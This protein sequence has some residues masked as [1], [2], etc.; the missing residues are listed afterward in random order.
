MRK[1]ITQAAVLFALLAST[2]AKQDNKSMKFELKKQVGKFDLPPRHQGPEANILYKAASEIQNFLAGFTRSTTNVIS[3]VDN[4]QVMYATTMYL[5]SAKKAFNVQIDTG[6]NILVIQDSACTTCTTSFDTSTS[7]S[8]VSSIVSDSIHYGDGSYTVG[9]KVHD[10]LAADSLSAYEVTGFNFLLGMQQKGFDTQDGLIGMSRLTDTSYTMFYDQLYQQGHVS[11]N[12]F[13]FYMAESTSQ[14]TLEIGAFDTSN[15]M[16]TADM[17]Y[18]PLF[19][20][21]LF[22]T[23]N[24][25]G[26]QVGT[27]SDSILNK[28]GYTMNYY[29]T[30]IL[31]T[32]TTLM[33][34]PQELY[35]TIIDKIVKHTSASLQGGSYYD[36]CTN[37][38]KYESL[39]L[40]MGSTWMEIPPTS[41]LYPVGGGWCMIGFMQNNDHNWLL[42]DVFL[43]NFYTIWDNVNSQVGIGP[44][45]TSASTW[46]TTSTMSTPKAN[47]GVINIVKD[48]SEQIAF[49]SAKVGVAV[50]AAYSAIWVLMVIIHHHFGV[51]SI[52]GLTK[53]NIHTALFI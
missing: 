11:S 33:Y 20:Q 22:Y 44:H 29:S 19:D 28:N 42:G 50:L 32:G 12:V 47:F 26:F 15:L 41:Y 2:N 48:I 45:K 25:D 49:V 17:V 36:K 24:V 9:Y 6:S 40:L 5:G 8:F 37:S 21:S 34:V 53:D 1:T 43:K 7:T 31:D 27:N 18:L 52:L 16:N 23:V 13:A 30:A 10:T 39:Y 3:N 51:K 35:H 4:L 14:S 38:A 46:V